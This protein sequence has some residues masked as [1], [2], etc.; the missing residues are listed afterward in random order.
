MYSVCEC[1][2]VCIVPLMVLLLTGLGYLEGFDIFIFLIFLLLGTRF[3]TE[4]IIAAA[5][6]SNPLGKMRGITKEG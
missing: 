6:L 3:K 4:K 2:T 1:V 5:D